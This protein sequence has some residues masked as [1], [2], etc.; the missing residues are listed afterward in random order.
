[1]GERGD[2]SPPK[3]DGNIKY[4]AGLIMPYEKSNLA[5]ED[6]ESRFTDIS[7]QVDSSDTTETFGKILEIVEDKNSKQEQIREEIKTKTGEN[8][9]N[10]GRK[11]TETSS[12]MET[13]YKKPT[14]KTGSLMER[15]ES[16]KFKKFSSIGAKKKT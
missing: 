1:M 11:E 4:Q 13:E 6:T 3:Y 16:L 15:L 8:D 10:I 2:W 7:D 9:D 5:L 12:S 14:C